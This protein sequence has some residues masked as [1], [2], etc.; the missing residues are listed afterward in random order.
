MLKDAEAENPSPIQESP[1]LDLLSEPPRDFTRL[2]KEQYK[3]IHSRPPLTV[4]PTTSQTVPS[5]YLFP[6]T[7]W[8]ASSSRHSPASQS[9]L[10]FWEGQ[11]EL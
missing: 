6:E 4:S 1:Q 10:K 7:I 11:T 2:Q 8:D 3:E 5:G 9:P